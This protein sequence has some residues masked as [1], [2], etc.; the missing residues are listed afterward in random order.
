MSLDGFIAGPNGEY[1]SIPKEP[2]IDWPAFLARFDTALMGRRTYEAS[3]TA[4]GGSSLPAMKTY[5]FSRTLQTVA[6]PDITLLRDHLPE[7]LA[8]LRQAPGKDIWL[9]GGG[10]LFRSLL[11]LGQV[12][13]VEVG[14]VPVLLGGGIPFLPG[15]DRQFP[16]R[17]TDSRGYPSG[18]TL[19]T[20]A[21]ET[22]RP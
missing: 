4:P 6:R 21:V 18:I 19:L 15:S 2:E 16:L 12:D 1:N 11:A 8:A 20:Y 9:F 10:N 22:S 14:L 17:L 13:V 3:L 5:V 7:A